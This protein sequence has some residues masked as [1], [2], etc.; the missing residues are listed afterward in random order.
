MKKS[1]ILTCLITISLSLSAQISDK[2]I[3]VGKWNVEK[4]IKQPPVPQITPLV[5]SFEQATFDFKDNDVF[6]LSTTKSTELF[7]MM[8]SEVMIDTKWKF[9]KNKQLLQIGNEADRYTTMS[10]IVNKKNDKIIFELEESG[11]VFLMKK[12]D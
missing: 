8:M 6:E 1:I 5:Q 11:L 2:S 3:L 12:V 4:T 10:I 9:N 7:E